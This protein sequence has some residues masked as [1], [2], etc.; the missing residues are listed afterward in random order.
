MSEHWCIDK[1]KSIVRTFKI[2]ENLKWKTFKKSFYAIQTPP[3]NP[4]DQR[5]TFSL[6]IYCGFLVN[7]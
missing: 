6:I 1:K 3:Q 7:S 2:K 5:E 4:L